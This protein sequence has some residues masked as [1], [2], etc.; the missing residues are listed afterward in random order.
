VSKLK[1]DAARAARAAREGVMLAAAR[2]AC[3]EARVLNRMVENMRLTSF[4]TYLAATVNSMSS[5]VPDVLSVGR[6]DV[7]AALQR[8]RPGHLWPE[9][10]RPRSALRGSMSSYYNQ[11]LDTPLIGDAVI[12]DGLK[13][14][15]EAVIYGGSLEVLLRGPAY[16]L[17]TRTGTARMK[18][19]AIPHTAVGSCVGRAIEEVV[20]HALLRGRG[21]V[22]EKAARVGTSTV[23][24]FEVGTR[25]LEM[26]WAWG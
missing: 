17:S 18:L 1:A 7:G 11:A 2:R 23:V 19:E 14:W 20:D 25:P 26:P 10:T 6:S 16:T 13:D 9:N 15:I 3:E 5:I 8:I 12:L 24:S 4:R 21:F 22:V